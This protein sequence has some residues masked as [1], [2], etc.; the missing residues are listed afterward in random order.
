MI[1]SK[2]FLCMLLV[3]AASI[4]V[5]QSGSVMGTL[6]VNGKAI[7]L[8]NALALQTKDWTLG[9]N[10][11]MVE[12]DV[13]KLILSDLP[14]DDVEDDFDLAARAK[15]GNLN[16]VRLEFGKKGEL[17]SGNIY[18]KAF[19]GGTSSLFT[20]HIIFEPKGLTD[21]TIG[22]K[23]RMDKP[24]EMGGPK[25][26]FNVTFSA[27]VQVEPKPTTEGV[28]AAETAPAKSVLEFLRA[29]LAKD[30]AALKRVL[31]KE[32][33]EMLEKPEGQES[34][35]AMLGQFFREEEVKQ[36]KIVRVF[37]FGNRAWVEGTSKRP[38]QSGGAPTDVTYR[39][40]AVKEGTE[41]KV[42]PM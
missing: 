37:D 38:S 32:F 1:T 40:R 29:T 24:V 25:H 34:V 3:A 39:I 13:I 30:V 6:T 11:K 28:G 15:T 41:W 27:T 19:E 10:H 9:A 17:M 12:V 21:K 35:M 7:K 14:V 31:R 2:S 22:G 33:V 23:V 18:H 36:L 5:G 26:D 4:A 16:G 8:S 42:Q 20:S